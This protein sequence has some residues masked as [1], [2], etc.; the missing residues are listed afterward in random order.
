MHGIS[1]S[2]LQVARERFGLAFGPG[3][4]DALERALGP[5]GVHAGDVSRENASLPIRLVEAALA[6]LA[7]RI[8]E[9]SSG[10]T[11]LSTLICEDFAVV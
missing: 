4:D 2:D 11:D 8:S 3:L 6:S 5:G 1:Y 9:E 7:E 10:T